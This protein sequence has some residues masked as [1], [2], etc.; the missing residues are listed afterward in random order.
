MINFFLLLSM[1]MRLCPSSFILCMHVVSQAIPGKDKD[2]HYT[3]ILS[4]V[5]TEHPMSAAV[6]LDK[7]LTTINFDSL[8]RQVCAPK[9]IP[10]KDKHNQ[11][12]LKRGNVL[13]CK[14]VCLCNFIWCSR[15]LHENLLSNFVISIQDI[16]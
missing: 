12:Q 11:C 8:T 3:R 14:E 4:S 13:H 5:P 2:D 9:Q 16:R 15:V 10:I 7:L 6:P 1:L